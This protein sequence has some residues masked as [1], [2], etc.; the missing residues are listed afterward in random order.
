MLAA[1]THRAELLGLL[2]ALLSVTVLGWP[3]LSNMTAYLLFPGS[4]RPAHWGTAA[5]HAMPALSRSLL[6]HWTIVAC[7]DRSHMYLCWL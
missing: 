4:A 1:R 7:G 2:L 3:S 6:H 5:W